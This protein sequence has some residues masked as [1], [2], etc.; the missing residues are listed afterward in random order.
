MCEVCGGPLM[1]ISVDR[2]GVEQGRGHGLSYDFEF[3]PDCFDGFPIEAPA[4]CDDVGRMLVT[5]MGLSVFGVALE[6]RGEAMA[7]WSTARWRAGAAMDGS[8]G[9]GDA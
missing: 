5:A 4:I 6:E 3:C 8:G 9:P 1:R 7:A 2:R